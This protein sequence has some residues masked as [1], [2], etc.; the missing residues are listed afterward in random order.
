LLLQE[1]AQAADEAPTIEDAL[2]AVLARVCVRMGWQAGRL[3]FSSDAGD[4]AQ[5]TFWHLSD[6]ERLSSFRTLAEE[7]RDLVDGGLLSRVLQD[8]KPVWAPLPESTDRGPGPRSTGTRA[9]FAFPI[10]VGK[11]V[12]AVLEFFSESIEEPRASL[13][14]TL[15]FVCAGLGGI[16]Q[17]KPAEDELRRSER[18]YRALFENAH[19][20][21]LIIDPG[22]AVVLDAN[23]RC[24]DI[25]GWSRAELIGQPLGRVW[26]DPDRERLHQSAQAQGGDFEAQH[27]R[28][29]GSIISVDVAA[30]PVEFRGRRAVW[31]SNR[32]VTDR[33]RTLEALRSSEERYR[34]LFDASPLPMWVFDQHTLRFLQVNEAAIARYGYTREEFSR[35]TLADIRPSETFD[36]L[37]GLEDRAPRVAAGATA[38]SISRHK[39]ASGELID[40]EITSHELEWG[41]RMARL[42][43]ANE[44]TE[45]L[46][47]EQKLWHAA[48]YDGLTGLPNRQLFM[49]RLGQA[50]ARARGRDSAG[51]AVLFLDLDRFKIVNDS[52]GH[53]AGDQLLV[54]IARRLE[55][56][57]RA[58]DTVARLGGDEFA[59]LVEGV[60]DAEAAG[61]VADRVQRELSSPFEVNGQE[62]FTSASIGIA[63]GGPTAQR[64]EDLVRDADTAMY[65]AK[66]QGSSHH[67]VFD[68]TMHDRA[69][70]VLQ[71]ESDLRRAIDRSELRVRYQPIVSLSGNASYIVGFEALVRWQ[72]RQRGLVPPKDF[73]PMAEETGVIGSVG[74]WVL[75]ESCRQMRTLQQLFPRTPPLSLSV[76]VSGRQILQPDLVEQIAAVLE[77]TGFDPRALRLEL[78][79]TVLVENETAALRCLTRLRQ[80]G[81]KL[82]IDDFGTGY[83]SLSYLHRMP[84]DV[85][86]IDASFISTMGSDEKN[87][88]IVE[89]VVLLGKNLGVEVV[90]EG[91]E[92][93]AQAQLLQR[94]GC[95]LLQGF[96][97]SKPVDIEQAS[98]LVREEAPSPVLAFRKGPRVG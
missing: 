68:I 24:T 16:L 73:I 37:E 30:G 94:L 14:D 60:E 43:V 25:Y 53:R 31:M 15:G 96:Y 65:R 84:I 91:V 40:V 70:A 54:S 6:P 98:A 41:G 45:R 87:R 88:R 80:L 17:R 49:E 9:I 75:A 59:V 78:T 5:R 32:D 47:A 52:M 93:K 46:R 20:A 36:G 58:G 10:F 62:V 82:V 85:L 44:V 22:E 71:L 4:L 38:P 57:R 90:A 97:F 19:D 18:E 66:S 86:K 34:L 63:L 55:R 12:L 81:L 35:M 21:I 2:R 26:R 29:D 33:H 11:R 13:L 8:G 1:V 28:K 56:I 83:S 39:K 23:Q 72:H 48:F 3:Q 50:Q 77:A 61:R 89:T 76:N 64:S 27:V 7:R 42:V 67:A 79:E 69:V 95:D 51:L 74:R 92:T